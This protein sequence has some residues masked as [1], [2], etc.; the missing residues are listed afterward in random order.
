[1]PLDR[2]PGGFLQL[3]FL[4][5][6]DHFRSRP[7]D[8]VP[9]IVRERGGLKTA[10]ASSNSAW[11]KGGSQKVGGTPQEMWERRG[12]RMSDGHPRDITDIRADIDVRLGCPP[13]FERT[14]RTSRM[15]ARVSA[16][17]RDGHCGHPSGHYGHWRTLRTSEPPSLPHCVRGG[18][19][20]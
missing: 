17:I 6:Y 8:C 9:P 1:M 10:L 13:K 2:H 15:S 7:W 12:G 19:T 11:E 20:G 4:G 5:K 18:P 3:A 16:D 14:L